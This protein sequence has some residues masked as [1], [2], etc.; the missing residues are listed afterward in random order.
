MTHDELVEKLAEHIHDIQW[1][2]WMKYLFNSCCK[3]VTG[4]YDKD[5][6]ELISTATIPTW[7]CER[8][9][10]QMNTSYKGLPETEKMSDKIEAERILDVI[11][12]CQ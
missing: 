11:K 10:R 2:G 7:A 6:T 1:S 8:W 12:K 5:G 4:R 3:D 9:S